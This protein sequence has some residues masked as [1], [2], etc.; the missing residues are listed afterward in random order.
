M[1]VPVVVAVLG[2]VGLVG[3]ALVTGV[4]TAFTLLW[5]RLIN[6]ETV[7]RQQYLYTRHLIDHIYRSAPPPP[8][9]PPEYISHLYATGEPE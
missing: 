1:T 5:R 3:A 4:V 2:L 7:N 6:L 8:P 9:S